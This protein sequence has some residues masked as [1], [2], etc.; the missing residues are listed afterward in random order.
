MP[1]ATSSQ[2]IIL[3]QRQPFSNVHVLVKFIMSCWGLKAVIFIA[4]CY[5]KQGQGFPYLKGHGVGGEVPF[6]PLHELFWPLQG[7][8]LNS[9]DPLIDKWSPFNKNDSKKN[10]SIDNGH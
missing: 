2:K 10:P 8:P 3:K 4:C 6:S 1:T 5:I 7:T 9:L